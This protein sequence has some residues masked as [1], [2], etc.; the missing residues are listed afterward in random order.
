MNKE[1]LAKLKHK[2]ESIQKVEAG[3]GNLGGI[4]DTAQACRNAIWKV[5]PYLELNLT[6]DIK[7]SQKD[8]YKYNGDKRKTKEK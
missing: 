8:F 4:R 1:L 5:K 2:K 7:G 6:R 3:R